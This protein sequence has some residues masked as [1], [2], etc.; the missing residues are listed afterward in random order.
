MRC[1]RFSCFLLYSF[2]FWEG[3]SV[4][5]FHCPQGLWTPRVTHLQLWVI[6]A[7]TR[8][9]PFKGEYLQ[10]NGLR[11]KNAT[12]HV[13][14]FA[15]AGLAHAPR[16]EPKALNSA[17]REEGI[18]LCCSKRKHLLCYC[19]T[20]PFAILDKAIQG[21]APKVCCPHD[22]PSITSCV[23]AGCSAGF[24]GDPLF[25]LKAGS[26]DKTAPCNPLLQLCGAA[27][28]APLLTGGAAMG[29]RPQGWF[30]HNRKENWSQYCITA[31]WLCT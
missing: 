27:P 19:S 25:A 3:G 9:T 24:R 2:N 18:C 30:F 4:V 17:C 10:P 6:S 26:A 12:L 1:Y 8:L 15:R 28:C 21:C 14:S 29:D 20:W 13:H 31:P 7:Q 16:W 22:L 5:F 11:N 23:Q